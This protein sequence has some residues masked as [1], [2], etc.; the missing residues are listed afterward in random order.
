MAAQSDADDGELT[1]RAEITASELSSMI[2]NQLI[3]EQQGEP[4]AYLAGI[5]FDGMVGEFDIDEILT[6]YL[7][8]ARCFDFTEDELAQMR[9]ALHDGYKRSDDN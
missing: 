5:A 6:E 9:R 8:N 3:L 2:G 7:E 1:L 4:F